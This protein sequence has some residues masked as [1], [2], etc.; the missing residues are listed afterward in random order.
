MTNN[1]PN[2]FTQTW[3]EVK[4]GDDKVVMKIAGVLADVLINNDPDLHEGHCVV[5]EN[6]QKTVHVEALKAMHGMLIS[7]SS[8]HKQHEE[9][10]FCIQ[11]T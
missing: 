4:D 3:F 11:P 7:A 9:T 5:C 2:A 8:W 10:G 6:G 1:V